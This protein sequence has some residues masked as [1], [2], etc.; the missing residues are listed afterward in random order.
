MLRD[1]VNNR[2]DTVLGVNVGIRIK[3]ATVLHFQTAILSRTKVVDV[4]HFKI[5]GC[6]H[7]IVATS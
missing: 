1:K 7:L 2:L 5:T 3:V 6:S 4:S